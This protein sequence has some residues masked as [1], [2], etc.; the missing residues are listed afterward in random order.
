MFDSVYY[1]SVIKLYNFKSSELVVFDFSS[2]YLSQEDNW[3]IVPGI[4]YSNKCFNFSYAGDGDIVRLS[5]SVKLPEREIIIHTFENEE[6]R[7]W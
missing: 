1:F 5:G 3:A 7:K 2:D 6:T 4:E